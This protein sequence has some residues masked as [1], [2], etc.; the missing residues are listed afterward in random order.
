MVSLYKEEFLTYCEGG[1]SVRARSNEK[2]IRVPEFVI[3]IPWYHLV[4]IGQIQFELDW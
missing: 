1:R 2:S 3:E 4:S